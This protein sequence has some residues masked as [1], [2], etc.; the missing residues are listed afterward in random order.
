[1]YA[2]M[3]LMKVSGELVH[4]CHRSCQQ[5]CPPDSVGAA[6]QASIPLH[7]CRLLRLILCLCAIHASRMGSFAA[8]CME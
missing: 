6:D 4:G 3:L 8:L 1:M 7:D 2:H 5:W